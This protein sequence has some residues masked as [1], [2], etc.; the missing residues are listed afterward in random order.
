[1]KVINNFM[2]PDCLGV[3]YPQKHLTQKNRGVKQ[4]YVKSL[5]QLFNQ[6]KTEHG[7]FCKT[8]LVFGF[9]FVKYMKKS[10]RFDVF[11]RDGFTC[12]YCGKKPPECILEVDHIL[13]KSK[14]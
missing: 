5:A 4:K 2:E 9:C 12:Q 8:F 6:P 14:I 7:I 13:P 1:M 10:L 11:N 3:S